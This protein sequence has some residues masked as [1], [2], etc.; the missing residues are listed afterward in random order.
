MG[1]FNDPC[2][3]TISGAGSLVPVL[4]G[5]SWRALG[6]DL[7]C[8]GCLARP[9]ICGKPGLVPSGYVNVAM[10]NGHL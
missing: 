2:K 8:G 7:R 6:G 4:H 9:G 1:T 3:P 10:E 5:T